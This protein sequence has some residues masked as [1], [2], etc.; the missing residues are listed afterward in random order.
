MAH[1]LGGTDEVE[2]LRYEIAEIG[3]SV[4]SSF[5]H[6]ASSFRSISSIGTVR[7]VGECVE[8]QDESIALQWAAIDRLPTFT[9]LRT[10][11]FYDGVDVKGKRVDVTKLGPVERHMFIGK[12][13]NHIENDNLRLLQNIRER[14]DK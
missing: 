12:L 8:D 3:R 4:R 13:I 7:D 14:I 2:S 10:S 1:Q 11:L 5:R 9:K 6:Y